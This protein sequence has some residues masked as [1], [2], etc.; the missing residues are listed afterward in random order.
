VIALRL[1]RLAAVLDDLSLHDNADFLRRLAQRF[2][3]G[4]GAGVRADRAKGRSVRR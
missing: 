2:E 4:E 1:S 3:D